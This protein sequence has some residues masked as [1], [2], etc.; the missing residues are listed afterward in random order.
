MSRTT[1]ASWKLQARSFKARASGVWGHSR[2]GGQVALLA[3]VRG[4]QTRRR[5]KMAFKGP[6]ERLA[7]SSGMGARN[8]LFRL[9]PLAAQF[10]S[11]RDRPIRQSLQAVTLREDGPSA[12]TAHLSVVDCM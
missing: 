11:K 3:L 8:C 5:S 10:E 9:A 7:R 12:A 2:H 6:M 4:K 1:V